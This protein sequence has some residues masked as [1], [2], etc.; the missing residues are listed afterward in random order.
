M[1]NT[2]PTQNIR[3]YLMC[4]DKDTLVELI[5]NAMSKQE[6]SSNDALVEIQSLKDDLEQ[7]KGNYDELERERNE[8]Q[9]KLDENEPDDVDDAIAILWDDIEFN[10][11]TEK[12]I[13]QARSFKFKDNSPIGELLRKLSYKVTI[14]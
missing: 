13:V 1:L 3:N 5:T 6:L 4:Q 2:I 7:L 9:D 14:E 10:T 12:A 11:L 8:L